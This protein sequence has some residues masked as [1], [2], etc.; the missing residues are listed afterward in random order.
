MKPNKR[1]LKAYIR[2][3]GMGMVISGS[4]ILARKMPKVGHWKEISAYECCNYT[5]TTST[6]TTATPATTT[7]T[8]TARAATTTTTATPTTTTTTTRGV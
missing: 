2:Y 4:V 1:D 6:T 7:T 5:S 8:T 3:D